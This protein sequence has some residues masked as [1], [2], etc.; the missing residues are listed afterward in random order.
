MIVVSQTGR[1]P[2]QRDV[3]GAGGRREAGRAPGEVPR[4]LLQR[5][6]PRSA[7]EPRLLPVQ[8]ELVLG[9]GGLPDTLGQAAAGRVPHV[10]VDGPGVEGSP[11]D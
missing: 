5:P 1:R 6:Q 11:G 10:H 3:T 7:P 4:D 8:V 2:V 9:D